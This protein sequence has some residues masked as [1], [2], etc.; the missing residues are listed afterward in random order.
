MAVK[1][2]GPISMSEISGEFGG[3]APLSLSQYYRT[4]GRVPN[5]TNNGINN[6][7]PESGTISMSNFYSTTRVIVVQY[8]LIGGG[9]GGGAGR[10]DDGGRDAGLYAT[11][12]G[13]SAILLGGSALVIV[14][15][16][17]GGTSFSDFRG[18]P[19]GQGAATVYGVGGTSGGNNQAGGSAP[20]TSYGAGGGGGGGDA[21]GTFDS[22]GNRGR[23]GSAGGFSTGTFN[24]IP[25]S[26][27][28]I[29]VGGAGLGHNAGYRGGNG[30]AGFVRLIFNSNTYN[31]TST[32]SIVVA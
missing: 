29:Q 26:T 31:F 14:G 23:G 24:I 25:G 7:V 16:G 8:E 6:T 18:D 12:G 9:G 21:P 4:V 10:D 1:A 32:G 2:S 19:V 28:S 30:A 22:S 17:A 20:G 11:S 13:Q 5:V 3:T 27:L 15:G